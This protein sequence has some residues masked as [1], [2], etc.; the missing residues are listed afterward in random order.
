MTLPKRK[1]RLD[2]AVVGAQ[3][4]GTTALYEY[5]RRH[6]A[7]SLPAGKEAPFFNRD[8]YY[9][10]GLHVFIRDHFASA[11]PEQA[12]GVISPQYMTSRK[13]TDRV[14]DALPDARIIAILR[15]PVERALSHY[16]M[17]LRRRQESRAV[18]D[19]FAALLDPSHAC[20]ARELPA[21]PGSEAQCYLAWG[22]YGRILAHYAERYPR[23]NVAILFFED[24]VAEPGPTLDRFLELIGVEPGYRPDNLGERV[25]E[26]GTAPGLLDVKALVE[27]LVPRGFRELLPR[28]MRSNAAYAL[29]R[30]SARTATKSGP[31]VCLSASIETAVTD[32]FRPDVEVLERTFG[33]RVPWPRFSDADSARPEA[34]RAAAL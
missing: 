20:T 4:S 27:R 15:D 12:W 9:R 26:G 16:K 18:D 28:S 6:P 34:P 7:V 31:P 29:E 10:R 19:A 24:L 1:D 23:G 30:L 2:F 32:F 14:A 25:F 13:I 22:E 21:A 17:A 5:L 3:K 11:S 33:F 8:A